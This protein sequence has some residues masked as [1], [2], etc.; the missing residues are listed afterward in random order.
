MFH[1]YALGVY[2]LLYTSFGY[3]KV[4]RKM[5]HRLIEFGIF[6]LFTFLCIKEFAVFIKQ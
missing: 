5:A 6:F 2:M 4:M 1:I 3:F